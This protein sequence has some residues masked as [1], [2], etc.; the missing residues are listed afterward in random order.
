MQKNLQFDVVVIGSGPAG[1]VHAIKQAQFGKRVAC[2]DFRDVPGGTCLNVGCI[3]SKTLLQ[4]SHEYVHTLNN[5]SSFGVICD[6]VSFDLE[7]AMKKKAS[8]IKMLGQGVLSLFR[9]NNIQ[10]FAGLAEFIA[11]NEL[12]VSIFKNQEDMSKVANSTFDALDKLNEV[13]QNVQFADE[14]TISG[15]KIVVATGSYATSLPNVKIDEETIV[16]STGSLSLKSVP[17][18]LVIIGAGVIG[19]EM[20]SVWSRLGSQVSVLE[21]ARPL[22]TMDED[23]SA[24]A[25]KILGKKGIDI[26]S[27]AEFL[28]Y[29]AT[30]GDATNSNLKSKYT[31]SYKNRDT[32]QVNKIED[33]NVILVATGRKP[34]TALLKLENIGVKLDSHGF[35]QVNEHYQTSVPNVYAIGDVCGKQM[36]AHKASQEAYVLAEKLNGAHSAFMNYNTVPSVIYTYPEIASVGMTENELKAANIDYK[37]AK[38]PMASNSRAIIT[39]NTE[40][41]TKIIYHVKTNEILGASMIGPNAGDMIQELVLAISFQASGEDVA[42]CTHSHPSFIEIAQEAARATYSKPIH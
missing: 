37:V 34:R 14:F 28:H 39:G 16:S 8:V 5:L 42:M 9:K 33:V 40:G 38:I 35:V 20:A 31:V 36:L 15:E 19:L 22:V 27:N 2:I 6:N 25:C 24:E 1:Y 21:Y 23:V 12:K 11:A 4:S 10:Y 13:L 17:E 26:I 29:Q 18:K 32:E 30:E 7:V 3:P 41:F